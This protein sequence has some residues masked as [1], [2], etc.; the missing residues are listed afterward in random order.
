MVHALLDKFRFESSKLCV[1]SFLSA[2]DFPVD[3]CIIFIKSPKS[4][5]SL[6]P[7]LYVFLP[8]VSVDISVF[9]LHVIQSLSPT[10]SFFPR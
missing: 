7:M 5:V 9:N 2:A 1:W 4:H 8:S 6:V 3:L 10:F